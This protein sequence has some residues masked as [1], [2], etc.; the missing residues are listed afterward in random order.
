MIDE[1]PSG[2]RYFVTVSVADRN[3]MRELA[4]RGLD[5]FTPTVVATADAV[6]IDGHLGVDQITDLVDTGHTV[7]IHGAVEPPPLEIAD[8]VESWAAAQGIE[9]PGIAEYDR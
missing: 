3:A 2:R 6:V 5:L 1:E 4:H 9:L 8:S 7:T